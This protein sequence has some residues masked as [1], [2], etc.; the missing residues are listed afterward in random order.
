MKYGM[1]RYLNPRL[2]S[3]VLTEESDRRET[4]DASSE[5]NHWH[6]SRRGTAGNGAKSG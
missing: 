1:I 4:N 2:M 6:G 5:G 3:C